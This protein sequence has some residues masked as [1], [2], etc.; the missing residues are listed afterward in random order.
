VPRAEAPLTAEPARARS[1][2]VSDPYLIPGRM[3]LF[4]SLVH[5]INNPVDL[6]MFIV[7]KKQNQCAFAD[8]A[9]VSIEQDDF[10]WDGL[11]NLNPVLN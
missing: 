6:E 1:L 8:A 4:A 9:S 11:K 10:R 3:R 5:R 2:S 7:D